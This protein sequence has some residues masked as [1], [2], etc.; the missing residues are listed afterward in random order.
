[1]PEMWLSP[2]M[3][4]GFGGLTEVMIYPACV[5]SLWRVVILDFPVLGQIDAEW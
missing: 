1:M 3:M 4:D 2:E 5:I